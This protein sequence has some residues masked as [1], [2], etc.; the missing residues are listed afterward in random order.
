MAHAKPKPVPVDKTPSWQRQASTYMAGRSFIDGA[1]H[2][3]LE[4]ERT[5]GAGRLRLLVDDELRAR[6]D[7]QRLKLNHA[8]R[9]GELEDVKREALRMQN[10][11]RA[12][13]AAATQ[14][15]ATGLSPLV[16]E[17]ALPDGKVAAL[18]RSPEEARAVAAEGRAVN[19]Y[20]LDE[21]G[22]LIHGFPAIVRA[23]EVFPGATVVGV[24][25]I[26]DP[27]EG[28]DEVEGDQIPFG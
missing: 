10:A 7:S 18:V 13:D 17:V 12:L 21:I 8:I 22:N 4:A 24:K 20:S 25:P 14:A 28:W 16:W 1:D 5:W 9:H 6:F 27:V 19:V 15:G 23:K 26:M 11:W 2:L 3:A